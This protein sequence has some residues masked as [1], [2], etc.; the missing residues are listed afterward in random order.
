[1]K[2]KEI[3][4]YLNVIK[5]AV[6]LIENMLDVDDEGLLEQLTADVLQPVAAKPV[7][8][9]PEVNKK[10]PSMSDQEW[11]K[12][13]IA[14]KKHIQDLLAIDVWPQAVPSFLIAEDSSETDQI[15]RANAVLDMMV[16]RPLE[17]VHFLDFGC[18]EGWIAKQ[19][20][21]RGVATSTGY[22]IKLNKNWANLTGATYTH[23][24]NELKRS[25]YDVVMLYDVLDHCED[26]ELLMTQV[27]NVLKKDGVVYV[28][29]HPW[30]SKHASHLYKSG[31]NKAYLHLFLTYDEI[32]TEVGQTPMFTRIEKK[33]IEA[34][35]W[36]FHEFEIKKERFIKEPVSDFFFVPSFKELIANEQQIP[37]SEI[38]EFLTLLQIQFVDY[39]LVPKK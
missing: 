17:N 7:D 16:D 18:G 8:V 24:Y 30:T 31:V 34:Y 29:C 37:M 26:P 9:H 11:N 10:I 2:D 14:R 32:V 6:S 22:D 33:P 19:V 5:R 38:D 21:N 20:I 39:C 27:K 36:W 12:F 13:L 35:H 25:F 15:N 28:R 4:R 3:R 1:M 23:I